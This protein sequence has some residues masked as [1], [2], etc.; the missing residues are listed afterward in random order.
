[1]CV[2]VF[3]ARVCVCEPQRWHVVAVK[4][5]FFRCKILFGAPDVLCAAIPCS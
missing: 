1:M 4:H 2:A 5:A 3:R